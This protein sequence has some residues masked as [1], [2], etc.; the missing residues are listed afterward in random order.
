[1]SITRTGCREVGVLLRDTG[2]LDKY[3]F[4]VGGGSVDEP[5]AKEIGATGYAKSAAGAVEVAKALLAA[6]KGA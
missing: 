6:K 2:K 3:I 4:L 5:Y 1:M